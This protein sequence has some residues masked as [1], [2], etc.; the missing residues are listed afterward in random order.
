MGRFLR[1]SAGS[2]GPHQANRLAV[3]FAPLGMFFTKKMLA[4]KRCLRQ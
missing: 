2:G 1:I 3:A 4:P